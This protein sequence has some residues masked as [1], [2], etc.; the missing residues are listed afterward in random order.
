MTGHRPKTGGIGRAA[1]HH[2]YQRR[3]AQLM[4]RVRADE[5]QMAL[6]SRH[7]RRKLTAISRTRAYRDLVVEYRRTGRVPKA[8]K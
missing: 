5:R 7:E 4:G 6:L 1:S 2:E 8:P 3:E